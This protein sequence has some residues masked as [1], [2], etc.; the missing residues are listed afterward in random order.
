MFNLTKEEEQRL[1]KIDTPQK[2]Q[3]FINK[4][5]MNFDYH[6]DTCLSPRQVL[7]KN[8]CHCI[9][10][11]LL[12]AL[13]LRL[14]GRQPL[15]LDM[16]ANDKDDDHVITIFKE[17]GKFG[18]ISKTNHSVLRYR[19]PVYNTIRELVMSFFHEYTNKKGEKTL[20]TYSKP[21][22]LSR[23]DHL[24]WETSEEDVWFIPDH[25]TRI[26]HQKILTPKQTRNLRKQDN[27]ERQAGNTTEWKK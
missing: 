27:I 23:F 1:R 7:K 21:V 9:E 22:N 10:G 19:E 13:I 18:C 20:R 2:V 6:K 26:K 15:I 16:E 17:D 24:N 14:Q 4:I 11:A 3:D 25:L 8:K 5:P 12:A